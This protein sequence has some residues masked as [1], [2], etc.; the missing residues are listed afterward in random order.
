MDRENTRIMAGHSP[1]GLTSP[2]VYRDIN[3][4]DH[5]LL[6]TA[7]QQLANHLALMDTSDELANARQFETY[8]RLSAFIVHDLKNLVAQL[9]LVV[10]NSE[11]HKNNPE[12]ITDAMETL[13]HSVEKMNRL[14][15]QLRKGKVA[16]SRRKVDLHDALQDVVIQQNN[17]LPVPQ[18]E[19]PAEAISITTDQD[20]LTAVLGHLVQNAQDATDKDGWVKLRLYKRENQAI[21]EIED[22]GCGMDKSFIRDRLF[23]PFDTTKGNAG[24]G[25]GVFEARQYVQDHG[26]SLEVVSKPGEGSKFILKLLLSD[27]DIEAIDYKREVI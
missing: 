17:A 15:S 7:G 18:I 3:W 10:K 22:S 20:R 16:L 26:G 13:T 11:K 4:E 9:S 2:R 24:M 5:D 12:F 6:K 25:I 1:D 19:Q 8:N 23:K 14:V 27:S 21:I